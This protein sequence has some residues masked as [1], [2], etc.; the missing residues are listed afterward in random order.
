LVGKLTRDPLEE[1]ESFVGFAL[2]P[3]GLGQS[4][5]GGRGRFALLVE[6]LE[7]RLISFD[8]AGQVA[9]SFFFQEPFLKER[10]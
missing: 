7:R 10:A 1:V 9:V 8:S 6:T 2:L 5:S 3:I 4:K